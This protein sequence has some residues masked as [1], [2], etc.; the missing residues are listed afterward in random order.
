MLPDACSTRWT[1]GQLWPRQPK[2]GAG[3]PQELI[4]PLLTKE[5]SVL[6]DA[7][8]GP[9]MQRPHG[10]RHLVLPQQASHKGKLLF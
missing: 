10:T 9:H 6:T 3:R 5:S 1:E 2:A 8:L 7:P 4:K